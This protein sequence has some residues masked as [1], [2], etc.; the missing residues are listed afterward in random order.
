M[1]FRQADFNWTTL[2]ADLLKGAG[3]GMLEYDGSRAAQA[4]LAGL[5]VFDAAQERRRQQDR[6]EQSQGA[7]QDIISK[8]WS[9]MTP[10]ERAA[11]LRLH[12]EEQDAYEAELLETETKHD[13]Q[14]GSPY[15]S[16][17]GRPSLTA[18]PPIAAQPP[19]RGRPVSV[20]PFDGW[21]LQSILPFGSDGALNRPTYRR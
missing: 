14:V 15:P 7:H 20:N 17:G 1:T 3:T 18:S 16:N 8:L 5:K 11:F 21:Y 2:W 12:P 19:H 4:A 6:Q 13:P 10:E 9:T